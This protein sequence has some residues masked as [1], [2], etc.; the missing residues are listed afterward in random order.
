[1]QDDETKQV[2]P[3][4]RIASQAKNWRRAEKRYLGNRTDATKN[5]QYHELQKLRE[6]VDTTEGGR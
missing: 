1:M 6:A 4:Q 2:T 5:A 3:D